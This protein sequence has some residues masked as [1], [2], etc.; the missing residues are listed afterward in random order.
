[1]K[2]PAWWKAYNDTKHNRFGNATQATMGTT[3]HAVK[4]AFLALITSLE[5]RTRLC[6]RGI[7][8]S[9]G[10]T[11]A[12]LK[13]AASGWEQIASPGLI[14]AVTPLLGYKFL[15]TGHPDAAT[16]SSVFL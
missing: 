10:L 11:H 5:F 2:H 4:G 13:I 15:T 1:V 14:V 8:R 12:Q 6:E 3:L 16:D 7:I 9:K